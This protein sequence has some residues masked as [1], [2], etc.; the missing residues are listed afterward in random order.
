M[1]DSLKEV[2]QIHGIE[3]VQAGLEPV[4]NQNNNP[5]HVI[6]PVLAN[7]SMTLWLAVIVAALV[8]VVIAL[9]VGLG[10]G[11]TRPQSN[12]MAP[13]ATTS[14]QVTSIPSSSPSPSSSTSPSPSTSTSEPSPTSTSLFN[15][16]TDYICPDANN[17]EVRN[18]SGGSGSSSY[19]IFCD[20]DISSNSKKDL[21]SSVQSSFADCLALC[22]SMNNFQDRTDVGCTYNF[23][24]TGSQDKGTCWC[25]SDNYLVQLDLSSSFSTDDGSKYKMSLI[26]SK[27][28]KIKGQALWSNQDNTTLFTYGGNSL[29]VTSADQGLWTYTIADGS[30]KLQ[31]TSIQPVRLQGGAYANAPEVQAAYWVGGFQ[32]SDTTPA[33]TDSTVNYATGMIQFNT[34]TGTLT[35]L[36]APF[37]P[38]QQGALVYLPVGGK[39][40]LVFVGGEVPSIKDGI[41]ASLTPN[42]WNYAWVYDIAGNKWYNQTTTGSVASRTQFCAVVEQDLSTSTYQIY[43]IGG[44]DYKSEESLTDVSYLSIPS[45]K[46]FQAGPLNKPRM[47]LVC[48]A[49]GRQIF[50]VGGR[51]AW[52]VDSGAGCYDMPAFIYDAQSEVIRTQFDPG[53]S[54]YS[55]PSATANDIK[56]S[57][58][59]STWADPALKSLFEKTDNSTNS[60]DAQPEPSSSASN[61]STEVGA[62]V[63]GVVGGIAGVAI[64]LA[65]IFFILRKRR[66]DSQNQPQAEKWSDNAPVVRG[67][68]GGEL[69][70]ED[71]RRE[72]EAGNNAR[73]E[74]RGTTRSVYELDGGQRSGV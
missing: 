23:E 70:A 57:P 20:A 9:A 45:F 50:G 48:Q 56:S 37:T 27:V 65:I 42:P 18:V 7:E 4:S 26:D 39:G 3:V 46:W 30:W 62:I 64:I 51:L 73:S 6:V 32:N 63:G 35:Q 28:P 41:N 12:H 24:G 14:S 15:K 49:Y 38:V 69:P 16:S 59:P 44:A 11:L 17:T 5:N 25:L 60:T 33:I 67:R 21:S 72:L 54:A 8:A 13:V 47:T 29:D 71:P 19:Y 52:A 53:L 2:T 31:Q 68:V 22:N 55:V 36:D 34:T 58:Y 10:V 74:L 61:S 1:T 40:I 66:R 43:V